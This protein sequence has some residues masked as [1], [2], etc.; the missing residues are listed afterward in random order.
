M[1]YKDTSS[2]LEINGIVTQ[3]ND[4]LRM[5]P[6]YI[7]GKH[8]DKVW[9]DNHLYTTSSEV[10]E[11]NDKSNKKAVYTIK[12]KSH[13]T[14]LPPIDGFQSKDK[15]FLIKGNHLIELFELNSSSGTDIVKIKYDLVFQDE[16]KLYR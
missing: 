5:R 6:E 9:I 7:I 16:K 13:K 14:L 4:T 8:G 1:V 2:G 3:T 12:S 15:L 10:Q 11:M